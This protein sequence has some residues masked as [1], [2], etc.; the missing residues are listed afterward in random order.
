VDTLLDG[1]P[2]ELTPEEVNAKIE[3]LEESWGTSPEAQSGQAQLM[4]GWPEG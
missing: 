1:P 3:E 4:G 2:P